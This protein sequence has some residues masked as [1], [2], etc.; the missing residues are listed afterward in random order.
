M[1]STGDF[2]AAMAAG[3]SAQHSFS[4]SNSSQKYSNEANNKY[5]YSV[6]PPA[7]SLVSSNNFSIKMLLY[8][9]AQRSRELAKINKIKFAGA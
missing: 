4:D 6:N 1:S 3:A 8:M 7:S 5:V 9:R 2:L